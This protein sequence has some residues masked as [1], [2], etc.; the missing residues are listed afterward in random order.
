MGLQHFH[1]TATLSLAQSTALS[2][3]KDETSCQRKQLLMLSYDLRLELGVCT[4]S[5]S[6]SQVDDSNLLSF[7]YA[8][9]TSRIH[10]AVYPPPNHPRSQF[11][12][13]LNSGH[14]TD[15]EH[16]RE[17]ECGVKVGT[18]SFG[19]CTCNRS[20]GISTDTIYLE[21]TYSPR[22]PSNLNPGPAVRF[23]APL[24]DSDI[25]LTC[26][27]VR[28]NCQENTSKSNPHPIPMRK[29]TPRAGFHISRRSTRRRK[30]GKLY[31]Q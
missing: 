11:P 13:N 10:R 4:S 25:G 3:C 26:S 14:T 5:L 9:A 7:R 23:D 18:S 19:I 20:S 28:R 31:N 12:T 17:R 8:G 21:P 2:K 27:Y 22:T 1:R 6:C 29:L 15:H 24:S 30:R 16:T